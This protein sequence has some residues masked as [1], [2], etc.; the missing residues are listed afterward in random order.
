M[1]KYI[2]IPLICTI[3]VLWNS[4]AYSED[5]DKTI[6]LTNFSKKDYTRNLSPLL[7]SHGYNFNVNYLQANSIINPTIGTINFYKGKH[8][9]DNKDFLKLSSNTFD[10]NGNSFSMEWDISKGLFFNNRKK[11]ALK[12]TTDMMFD[13]QEDDVNAV[14]VKKLLESNNITNLNPLYSVNNGIENIDGYEF[15]YTIQRSQTYLAVRTSIQ[16]FSAISAGMINYFAMK[17]TNKD[18]WVYKY[19]WPDV[20]RKF[21]DGW[22]WDPND[23]NTNTLYHA[24]AGALYYTI[25]RSNQYSIFE[26]FLWS[27]AG[28]TIWEYFGEWREQVSLND[29]ILT[30]TLGAVMGEFFFQTGN[31]IERNM[32]P[33]FY[34]ETILI[35]IDPASWLNKRLD[36]AN[37]GDMQVR[38]IFFNPIQTSVIRKAEREMR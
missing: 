20:K 38:L 15:N 9:I 18:D 36:T 28:S 19:K 13:S 31:F 10:V 32:K 2:I 3:L 37:S 33:S 12:F 4:D 25:A 5:K 30:P 27:F 6:N 26:S 29:V 22:Y 1:I 11:E 21:L 35:I 14:F 8:K 7:P 24:Y 23:F 16:I 34:R 17:Y